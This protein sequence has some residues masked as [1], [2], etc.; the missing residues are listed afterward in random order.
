MQRCR[1]VAPCPG[2]ELGGPFVQ[3]PL[4]SPTGDPGDHHR[5]PE[6]GPVEVRAT[7]GLCAGMDAKCCGQS[8]GLGRGLLGRYLQ[9]VQQ[10]HV[11]GLLE[12]WPSHP[13]CPLM[14]RPWET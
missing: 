13:T 1:L 8:P 14:L 3:R 5:Q 7:R 4:D 9:E 12:L 11:S 2:C 6:L 10:W